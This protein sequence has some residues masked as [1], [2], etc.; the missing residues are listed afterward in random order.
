[1]KLFEEESADEIEAI[2]QKR[3][4]DGTK[5]S[6][7]SKMRVFLTW[8]LENKPLAITAEGD[9]DFDTF[10]LEMFL[11]FI[12]EKQGNGGLSFSA[13]SVSFPFWIDFLH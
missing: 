6:Y 13:C 9:L 8:L 1:M 7:N 11:G 10:E 5:S 12:A 2:K 4:T 3:L